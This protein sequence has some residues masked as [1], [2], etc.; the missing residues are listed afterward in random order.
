VCL[1]CS[2]AMDLEEELPQLVAAFPV[3][4][5]EI[6]E[7]RGG[8]IE[9]A[10]FADSSAAHSMSRLAE[11]LKGLGSTD[12]GIGT[13]GA[14]NWLQGYRDAVRPFAV[15]D[16]W[17]IDP[18][19]DAP[20][21]APAGRQR[22]VI[23]PRMAFGSGSHEST[24]LMLMALEDLEFAGADVLDVGTGSGVLALAAENR[25]ARSVV[26]LD[27]DGTAIWVARQIAAEQ[28]WSP[29]VRF[30][31]GSLSSI[32]EAQFQLVL[33]N[34]ISSAF[35]P[36]LDDLS[37][38]LATDGLLILAGLLVPEVDAV[39]G[40]LSSVGLESRNRRVLGE[41]ASLSATLADR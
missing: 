19:P 38:L 11:V 32:G 30:V 9:I 7:P 12:L 28:E 40:S 21:S 18:H 13:L 26:A 15:G 37:R 8:E 2:L 27:I 14:E 31:L 34:M 6:G 3:L 1:R 24:R 25:G 20:S 39:S 17:W 35:L 29:G 41:W 22:L 4:G 16:T 10:I 36:I 5:I 23:E 33:C